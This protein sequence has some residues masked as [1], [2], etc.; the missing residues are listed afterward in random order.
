M[1]VDFQWNNSLKNEYLKIYELAIKFS[2]WDPH[3]DEFCVTFQNINNML[4]FQGRP[5]LKS[6]NS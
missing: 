1:N 5:L 2:L 6:T 4:D 3:I